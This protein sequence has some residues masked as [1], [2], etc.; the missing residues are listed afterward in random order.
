M[1]PLTGR[2]K[3]FVQ[4]YITT[5]N[6]SAAA[7]GVGFKNPGQS[8][9]QLMQRPQ[10]QAAILEAMQRDG[11]PPEEVIDRLSQQAR[12]NGADFMLFESKPVRD[13]NGKI[14]TDSLGEIITHRVF[15]GINWEMVEKYGYLVKGIKYTRQGIPY[16]EFH[17]PQ[18]AIELIGKAHGLFVDRTDLN[19]K[20]ESLTVKVIKGVTLDEL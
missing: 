19:V 16:L 14:K 1:K 6:A 7:A 2:E 5:W 15:V 18:R 3:R 13:D 12:L 10:V 8:G 11:M 9:H 17:D 4:L 20:V